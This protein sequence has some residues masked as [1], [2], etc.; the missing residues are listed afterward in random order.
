MSN[1]RTRKRALGALTGLVVA[2]L[3]LAACSSGSNGSAT[4]A[5]STSAAESSTA[6]ATT[7]G[8]AQSSSAE[9]STPQSSSA[10][11]S[12]AQSSAAQS[13]AASSSAES[14]AASSSGGGSSDRR[15]TRRRRRHQ[16]DPVD[17]GA[18]GEAGQGSGRRLQ[19]RHK[20]QVALTVVPND[21]YVAKVGAAAGASS[22]P[23][24]SPP[25]SCTCPTGHPGPLPGPDQQ[26]RRPVLRR[27]L[28]QGHIVG[29][30]LRQQEVR[31]AVRSRPLGDDVEQ[32]PLQGG[33]PRPRQG[34]D[35]AGRIRRARRRR[36]PR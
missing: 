29:G 4:T 35:D 27:Q 28:N 17:A 21:D 11:S 32:V 24:C 19:L 2:S 31:R 22:C 30:H 36:L 14:S 16:A 3:V 13:S 5:A 6:A 26:D 34:T 23:T 9:S 1:P 7:E 12:S 10:G 33:R 20:N 25:T 18:A 8:S 15:P